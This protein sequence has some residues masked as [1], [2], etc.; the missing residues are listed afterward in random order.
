MPFFMRRRPSNLARYQVYT[1]KNGR[2]KL[3][4][5]GTSRVK[6]TRQM[7]LLRRLFFTNVRPKWARQRQLLRRQGIDPRNIVEGA[8]ARN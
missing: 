2:V 5:K 4:S 3:F 1:R 7:G 8:R 6:A